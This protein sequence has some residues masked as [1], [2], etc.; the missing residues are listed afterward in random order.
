[1]D[2]DIVHASR[3]IAQRIIAAPLEFQIATLKK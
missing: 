2:M 3:V 1:M